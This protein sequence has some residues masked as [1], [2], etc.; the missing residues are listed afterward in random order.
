MILFYRK[1]VRDPV[2]GQVMSICDKTIASRGKSMQ[3]TLLFLNKTH[4]KSKEAFKFAFAF[5]TQCNFSFCSAQLIFIV[6]GSQFTGHTLS[7]SA[8]IVQ[9]LY[10]TQPQTMPIT[11]KPLDLYI[12]AIPFKRVRGG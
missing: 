2:S 10:Y 3:V 9:V 4:F 11:G 5:R 8:L 7:A 6:L 12:R 1:E